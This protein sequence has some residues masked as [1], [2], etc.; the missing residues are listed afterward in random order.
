MSE[1]TEAELRNEIRSLVREYHAIAFPK[2]PFL[3]GIPTIPE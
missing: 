1:R 2:K 3:G